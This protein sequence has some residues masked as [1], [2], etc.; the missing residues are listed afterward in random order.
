MDLSFD[1]ALWIAWGV[2][3]LGILGIGA[4]IY[5]LWRMTRDQD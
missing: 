3:I 2:I 5:L 4:C 1:E